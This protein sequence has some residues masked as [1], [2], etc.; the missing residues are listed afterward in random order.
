MGR[1]ILI[2]EFRVTLV[3]AKSGR[4]GKGLMPIGLRGVGKTVLL[5][6]FAKQAEGQGYAV[7]F[8]EA[9]PGEPF[10]PLLAEMLDELVREIERP[11]LVERLRRGLRT[12]GEIK[13]TPDESGLPGFSLA[14]DR[15]NE[16]PDSF[17]T[18]ATRA[19]VAIGEAGKESG[20][21]ILLAIDEVQAL[22]VA[23]FA[24][25]I[26]AIH[27]TTQLGL[28]VV[29]VATG[30]PTLRG[31]AG[32]AR[33]YAERLF[34]F[35]QIG[36]LAPDDARSAIVEPAKALGVDVRPEAST[37]IVERTRGYPYFLQEWAFH[38]WN[39][40]SSDVIGA[41][42]VLAIEEVVHRELDEA[43]FSVRL[44]RLA[45]AER[46]YLYA[47]ATLGPG[48]HR[49]Q[50]VAQELNV[51][52]SSTSPTRSSLIEKGIVYAPEHGVTTFTVPLFDA[53][54]RRARDRDELV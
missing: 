8:L 30:L 12:I 50:A 22:S 46:R 27:R 25:V 29:L 18:N 40:A 15:G 48:P 32:K 6:H 9:R 10:S 41:D 3:R 47:M 33:S 49:S 39:H 38:A 7:A 1:D 36:S 52:M 35:P 31:A 43:F 20:K 13:V 34:R 42:D 53:F 5:N 11:T 19:L 23:D 14:L 37:L 21:G 24:A 17:T 28:P 16:T 45:P 44:D 2:E 54:L 4:P 26:S 51:K